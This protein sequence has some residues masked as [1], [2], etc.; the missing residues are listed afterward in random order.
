MTPAPHRHLHQAV[1]AIAHQC[2]SPLTLAP[3]SLGPLAL[4]PLLARK[5][6]EDIQWHARHGL[7]QSGAWI[8]TW[9]AASILLFALAFAP[10]IGRLFSLLWRVLP[11]GFLAV[12]VISMI[13]AINGGRFQI[14]WL[15]S[16]VDSLSG[17]GGRPSAE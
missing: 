5:D 10:G 13:R 15:S 1:Q 16:F 9:L 3:W 8:L 6:D 17:K 7:V 2:W 4:I 11:L 14:A 12:S